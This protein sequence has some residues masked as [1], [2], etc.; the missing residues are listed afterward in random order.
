MD[1]YREKVL[2]AIL[3]YE[4]QLDHVEQYELVDAIGELYEIIRSIV[5]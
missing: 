5:I 1:E 3:D 4:K 2:K